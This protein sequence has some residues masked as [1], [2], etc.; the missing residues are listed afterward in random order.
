ML[1]KQ[2]DR[3]QQTFS[4]WLSTPVNTKPTT[5]LPREASS[6]G[7]LPGTSTGFQQWPSHQPPLLLLGSPGCARPAVPARGLRRR[8]R[9]RSWFLLRQRPLAPAPLP[10]AAPGRA[11]TPHPARAAQQDRQRGRKRSQ[12]PPA[13]TACKESPKSGTR[14][15]KGSEQQKATVREKDGL[16]NVEVYFLMVGGEEYPTSFKNY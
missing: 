12:A 6:S 1:G 15:G 11:P 7:S 9:S 2:T 3:N 13:P 8:R 10:G 5:S 14:K 16:Q 4:Y